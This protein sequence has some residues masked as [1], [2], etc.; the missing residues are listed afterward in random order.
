MM[1]ERDNALFSGFGL[2]WR[3]RRV[4]WWVFVV[5]VVCGALGTVPA[6]LRLHHA[7]GHNLAGQ[8]LTNRFDLGM[9]FELVRLPDVQL[10][11][12]T[13]TSYLFAFVFFLF[14]LFVTGGVLETYCDDRR[15][16]TGEFFA[17]S[18]AYFWRFVRL[19]LLSMVPFVVVTIIYQMLHKL[20]DSVGDRAIADQVGIFM[21]LGA[22]IIFLLLALFVRLWFDMAQ[23]RAVALDE[24]RMWRNTWLSWR[25]T[26][27]GF[28][29]LYGMY[30][31]IALVGWIITALGFVIW[32]QLPATAT[33]GVFLIFELI[34]FAQIAARLWQLAGATS[35]YRLHAEVIGPPIVEPAHPQEVLVAGSADPVAESAAPPQAPAPELPPADA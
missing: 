26:W 33:G 24:R 10:L 34:M 35:W 32:A 15:L 13:T 22:L 7:L 17:A 4:L 18:G 25:I 21:D 2:L 19:L 1:R 30:F 3:R 5:N 12:F 31:V 28:G 9:F 20:A 29:R 23:V 6:W 27:Q 11:R 8:P 14:M 16:G